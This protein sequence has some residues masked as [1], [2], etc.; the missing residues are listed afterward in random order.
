MTH[1]ALGGS[2]HSVLTLL[3]ARMDVAKDWT[4][5]LGCHRLDEDTLSALMLN[6]AAE[7]NPRGRVLF[8][9]RDP[10]R[11]RKNVKAVLESEFSPAQIATFGELVNQESLLIV[12]PR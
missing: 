11:V 5:K 12:P 8:S 7:A 2:Y 1:G 6:Y 9:S 10:V 3:E 4:A